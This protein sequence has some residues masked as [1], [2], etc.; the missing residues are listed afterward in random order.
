MAPVMPIEVSADL[1]KEPKS[2]KAVEQP[3]VLVTTL[4]KLSTTATSTPR[5]RRMASVWDAVLESV[6][7]P[8]PASAEASGG[9]IEDAGEVVIASISSVHA[10]AGPLEAAPKNWWEKA[11]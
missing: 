1:V 10:E 4:P 2:E 9:N 11:F 3:K 8:P 7:T 6:K 5:K